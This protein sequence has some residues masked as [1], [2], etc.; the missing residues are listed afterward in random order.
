MA[1]V[2]TWHRLRLLKCDLAIL[3]CTARG[4]CDNT[5][6]SKKGA[7]EK[8]LRRVFSRF[9]AV[10]FSGRKGSWKRSKKGFS[11][12]GAEGRKHAFPRWVPPYFTENPNGGSQMGALRPLLAI[13]TSSSTIVHFCGPFGPLSEG[14]FRRKMVTI[15]GNRGQL[16]TSTLSPHLLS[17]HSDFPNIC[18]NM[19]LRCPNR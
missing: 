8:A 14:N 2:L 17:L 16:W 3:G 15:V 11:K 18:K 1:I 7:F 19:C 13:C 4:S 6:S 5:P 9:L 10:G 12:R